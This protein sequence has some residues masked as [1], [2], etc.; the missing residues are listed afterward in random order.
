MLAVKGQSTC[1]FCNIASAFFVSQRKASGRLR[2]PKVSAGM[3][4]LRIHIR[5]LGESLLFVVQLPELELHD[6]FIRGDFQ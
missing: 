5:R 4:T 1:L 3:P 6:L 2:P